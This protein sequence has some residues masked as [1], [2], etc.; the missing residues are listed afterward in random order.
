MPTVEDVEMVYTQIDVT[1][2]GVLNYDEYLILL[3]KTALDNFG[4]E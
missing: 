4:A 1:E 3:F 2:E